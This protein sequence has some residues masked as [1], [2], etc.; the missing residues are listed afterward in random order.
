M[1]HCYAAFFGKEIMN[2]GDL[3]VDKKTGILYLIRTIS[4]LTGRDWLLLHPVNDGVPKYDL[5]KNFRRVA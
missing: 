1:A 5:A 4:P 2:V 3:V